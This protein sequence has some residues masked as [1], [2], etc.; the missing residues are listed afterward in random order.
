[1]NKK[2]II[3]GVFALIVC[4]LFVNVMFSVPVTAK[5]ESIKDLINQIFTDE[6]YGLIQL[7]ADVE[8]VPIIHVKEFELTFS[9]TPSQRLWI[10]CDKH[11]ELKAL[12]VKFY[13]PDGEVLIKG[14]HSYWILALEGEYKVKSYSIIEP[15]SYQNFEILENLRLSVNPTAE[16]GDWM[17]FGLSFEGFEF[18]D[19]DEVLFI[20]IIILAPSGADIDAAFA[21]VP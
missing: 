18:I 6:E 8:N 21:I 10:K 4:S 7:D 16:A 13:D 17:R 11:Y 12:Y 20:K 19:F 9:E 14:S 3:L 2:Q 5:G 1:M 15:V